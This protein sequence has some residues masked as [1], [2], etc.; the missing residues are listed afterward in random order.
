[1]PLP[2]PPGYRPRRQERVDRRRIVFSA[3]LAAATAAVL[4]LLLHR[5]AGAPGQPVRPLRLLGMVVVVAGAT[6]CGAWGETMRQLALTQL[7]EPDGPE[8]L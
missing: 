5:A 8:R 2:H 4:L 1:M 7:G 6:A 3:G